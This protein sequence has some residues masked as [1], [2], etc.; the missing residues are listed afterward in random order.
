M[1]LNPGPVLRAAE[2]LGVV[3]I[4]TS[5]G[6]SGKDLA[7]GSENPNV[8]TAEMTGKI[9]LLDRVSGNLSIQDGKGPPIA[10]SVEANTPVEDH[11]LQ[12]S[13]N[14]LR[15]GDRVTVRYNVEPRRVNNIERI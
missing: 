4:G 1:F 6:P 2:P 7:P 14:E 5:R 10:F 9:Y 11:H 8:K 12:I 3:E 13:L 15:P